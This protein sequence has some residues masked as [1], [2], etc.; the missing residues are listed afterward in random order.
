MEDSE[1]CAACCDVKKEIKKKNPLGFTVVGGAVF[2]DDFDRLTELLP[3][4]VHSL[5]YVF[6]QRLQVHGTRDDL[7]IV[8]HNLGVD[9]RVEG[10]RLHKRKGGTVRQP[11][12]GG[13]NGANA[14]SRSENL[15]WGGLACH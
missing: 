13:R 10:I 6:T 12:R 11:L 4:W 8:L 14:E 3:R 7:I 1:S 15:R 9:G 5:A 2:N